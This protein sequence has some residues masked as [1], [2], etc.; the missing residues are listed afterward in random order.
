M[1]KIRFRDYF[2]TVGSFHL[3]IVRSYY[4]G[5]T[6]KM[7][8]SCISA[9]MTMINIDYKYFAGSKDPIEII[10]KYLCRGYGTILNDKEKIRF[11]EYNNLVEKWKK[12]FSIKSNDGLTIR[13]CLGFKQINDPMFEYSKKIYNENTT[14]LTNNTDSYTMSAERSIE[15]IY[16]LKLTSSTINMFKNLKVI[17]EFGYIEPMKHYVI[18][19]AYNICN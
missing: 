19:M 2:G 8:P 14:F 16:A 10:D 6:V 11:F 12:M 18:D 7:T 5:E 9:C 13:K 17:N 4:D 3:P 15:I 1:F